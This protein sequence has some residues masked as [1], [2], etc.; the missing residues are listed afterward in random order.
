MHSIVVQAIKEFNYFRDEMREK[1]KEFQ[2]TLP[3]D[4]LA[5]NSL[6]YARKAIRQ[7][8]MPDPLR[9]NITTAL[10]SAEKKMKA[11]TISKNEEMDDMG[12]TME[13]QRSLVT[14]G[15][16]TS[17]IAH[18]VIVPLKENAR[19]L[20][21][22]E[23]LVKDLPQL[24]V[25]NKDITK[26]QHNTVKLFHFMSFVRDYAALVSMSIDDKWSKSDV[27]VSETWKFVSEGFAEVIK[28]LNISISLT[29]PENSRISI[30]PVD[31][32]SILTNL[33]TNSITAL[34]KIQ[35]PRMIKIQSS[36]EDNNF[37]LRFSDNGPG[38]KLE[39]KER[40]FEPLFT[41]N[42][43]NDMKTHGT[44]LGLT[45][46]HEVLRRYDGKI[47]LSDQLEYV[48]GA[49]FIIRIPLEK[50]PRVY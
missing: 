49:T 2:T 13:S 47:E 35:G 26:L 24:D 4:E 42:K 18:E 46:V 5:N 9:K 44:G 28:D 21:N 36:F 50:A 17:Y 39:D 37:V 15:L 8:D 48:P 34:K 31:L 45:I 6:Q 33:L 16:A 27:T 30:N 22:I 20:S 10:M 19:I 41:T 40:I 23:K 11:F 1:Q 7:V 38:V 12:T 32:E 14:L 3:P 29:D 25:V 43:S